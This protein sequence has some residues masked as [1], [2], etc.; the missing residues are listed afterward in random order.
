MWVLPAPLN[1]PAPSP[2][3]YPIWCTRA[4]HL[5]L[6]RRPIGT[7]SLFPPLHYRLTLFPQQPIA[8]KR[9]R[10][11]WCLKTRRRNGKHT[12]ISQRNK[13]IEKTT[14]QLR[15]SGVKKTKKRGHLTFFFFFFSCLK[16]KKKTINLANRQGIRSNAHSSP[17]GCDGSNH[18]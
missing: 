16:K 18:S 2:L 4:G 3:I 14:R 7:L 13:S 15:P 1:S 10:S 5:R 17:A 9:K 8:R 11:W 6:G 12:D